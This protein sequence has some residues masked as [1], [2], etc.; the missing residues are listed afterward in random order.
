[1]FKNGMRPVHPGETLRKDLLEPL[2]ISASALANELHVAAPTVN[3]IVREKRG[4]SPL[5]ALR[6]SRYFGG[7]ARWWLNMQTVYDLKMAKKEAAKQI[8]KEVR[9]RERSMA[10]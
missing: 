2:K 8:E 5:M 4:V 9:P 3:D 1:M 10:A 6:L 7:S